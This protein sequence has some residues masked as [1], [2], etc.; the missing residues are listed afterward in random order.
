MDQVT[1][2][3]DS[4]ASNPEPRCLCVLVLDTS[5]SMDGEPIKQLNE[6]LIELKTQLMSDALAQKR[7]EISIVTFGPVNEIQSCVTAENFTP[8]TLSAEADT[9]MGAA[10]LK[11]VEVVEGR[12]QAYKAS[13]IKYYRPWIMLMTDGAPTDLNEPSWTAALAKVRDGQDKK[14]FAFFPIG[15]EGADL[16]LLASITPKA[17]PLK[18]KGL[19]FRE[20]FKWLSSS[21]KSVSQSR[22]GEDVKLQNPATPAGWATV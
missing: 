2:S 13:G 11:A 5:G 1:F 4:F 12:K 9:P 14:A 22:P 21:L 19:S 17:S 18:L 6:G 7:V 8:P 10:L 20:L 3:T 16:A 15:V